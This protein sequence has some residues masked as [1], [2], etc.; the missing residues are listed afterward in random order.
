MKGL[1]ELLEFYNRLYSEKGE[2]FLYH[3]YQEFKGIDLDRKRILDIGCGR[4]YISLA[5]AALFENIEVT[6]VD[7]YEGVGH[8]KDNYN[9]L[10]GI[11]EQY[12]IN[13]INL[14]KMDFLKNDFGDKKFDIIVANH[15]LHHMV[16]ANGNISTD[17][18]VETAWIDLLKEIRRVLKDNGVVI[19]QESTRNS[20]WRIVPLRFRYVDWKIHPTKREFIKVIKKVF[21]DNI[22]I[23]NV[24]NHKLRKLY[25]MLH[26]N[27]L[28]TL[29][30]T[31]DFYIRIRK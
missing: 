19:L 7:E 11:I 10:R 2:I 1:N 30:I 22:E 20:I 4:G 5:L 17:Y 21:S 27:P 13:N 24:V 9:F 31:P 15:S 18:H 29:L 16:R 12:D 26:K 28:F 3:F 14:R 8:D 25:P 6:A 23:E